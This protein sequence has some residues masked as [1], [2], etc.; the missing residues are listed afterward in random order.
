MQALVKQINITAIVSSSSLAVKG[1]QLR[2]MHVAK[3]QTHLSYGLGI[4][5][6]LF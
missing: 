5:A 2:K 6:L 4:I 1:L 3:D